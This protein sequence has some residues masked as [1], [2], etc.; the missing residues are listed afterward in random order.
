MS[1]IRLSPL[2][3]RRIHKWA[4]LLL[5]LQFMLWTL[6]GSVMALLDT[7]KVGGHDRGAPHA[8]APVWPDG[9]IAPD[10]LF[11]ATSVTGL[12][13]RMVAGRPVYEVTRKDRTSLYDA[14]TGGQIRVDAE[15]ARAVA[16]ER[17]N[18]PVH[19]QSLL[20]EA[21][22]E[23]RDHRGPMWR[24]DFADEEH[25]SAYVSATTGKLLVMRGDTWRTWDFFWMLH[26]M[27]YSSRSSFNHPLIITVAF[28]TLWLSLTGL[29]LIIR[30][31][32][33]NDFR[34][35]LGRGFSAI[36]PRLPFSADR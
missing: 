28:G 19:A 36:R 22:L 13:L 2:L 14:R 18:A 20:Q 27:D 26:N 11:P 30:S 10:R 33:R 7:A 15:L 16:G 6:S 21:N 1:R 35:I 24:V 8:K 29:Y 17:T 3:L 25:S 34:W 12:S 31:F 32:R 4:G 5:G 9:L 23:A